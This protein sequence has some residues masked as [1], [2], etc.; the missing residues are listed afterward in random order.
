MKKLITL[1]TLTFV[2]CLCS[3]FTACGL[4]KNNE[5]EQILQIYDIYV[6]HAKENGETPLSYEDWLLSIKGE[7]GDKG[8]KGETGRGIHSVIV[9]N[10][11]L[12]ITYTDDLNNPVKVGTVGTGLEQQGTFGL[13]YY[14]LP[15]G[16][17]AVG[18]GTTKYLKEITIPS[19]YNGANVSTIIHQ[20][21]EGCE[22]LTKIEI[23]NSVTSIGDDAFFSC[24][25]LTSI[26]IPSSVTSIGGSAF[27]NCD[28]LT[29]IEIPNSVTS[30]GSYAFAYCDSLTSITLPFVGASLN[31]TSNTHFGYI[32]GA[33]DWMDNADYVPT[34][35]K[36]VIITGGTSIGDYAFYYCTSLTSIE[37]PDS[38]TSIGSAAFFDCRSL[39]SIETPNSVTSIGSAAFYN[40]SSLTSV[41]I[42]DSVTSIG[43]YAFYDCTSLTSIEIPNSVTSIGSAPFSSCDSLTS[44]MV[45]ENNENYKSKDGNLYSKDG[46]TLIQYAIGKTDT[47][48]TIPNSVTSI[49]DGAFDYCSSLTS[50]VIPNSVTSIGSLA[51]DSC[52]SL[53][54][55]VIGN[56]VTSIGSAAFYNCSSLT[57]IEIPN[58][59]TSIGDG[60]FYGCD[61][62]TS[63]VIPNS[64]TSIGMGAFEYCTSLT[65][66][67][68]GDSVTS[69]GSYAFSSCSSLTNV[70]YNGTKEDW[71]KINISSTNSYLTYATRYY[72]IENESDL[73]NDNGNYWHY[74]N[75]VPTKW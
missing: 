61:S 57:S 51:F 32:F 23:P 49:G 27:Q 15:D 35:L 1:L 19:T 9:I 20:G 30:I 62:L 54:S 12:Y 46:K 6:V 8:D 37:I 28:S 4:V 66:V 43:D 47:S 5:N 16:T 69:I 45:D 36:E 26:E 33:S 71:A 34:S 24:D 11:E 22:N 3:F 42:E 67:V 13:E 70:Y 75:S 44:I 50:I 65:S 53:T 64:V 74:V 31:G 41:V 73:P 2:V 39:T 48:F 29:S 68:I 60:A 56:S 55:V 40:C 17:Y 38:V 58:S 63:I 18:C 21:F 72:Y 52:D 7:K 14:P 59:V 25:S 10:G